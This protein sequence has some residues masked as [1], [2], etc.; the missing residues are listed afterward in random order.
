[1]GNASAPLAPATTLRR[2][3][4]PAKVL[5]QVRYAGDLSRREA[6]PDLAVALTSTQASGSPPCPCASTSC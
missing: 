5:G 3:E 6:G 4:G 1:M 2:L